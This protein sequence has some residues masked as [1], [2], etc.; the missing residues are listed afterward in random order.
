MLVKGNI[1]DILSMNSFT[2]SEE[3]LDVTSLQ[4]NTDYTRLCYVTDMKSGLTRMD[5]GFFTFYVKDKNANVITAR[6]FD[7]SDFINSGYTAN[8]FVNKPV[9]LTFSAQ[10]YN[11]SWSLIINSMELWTGDFDFA[12]FIGKVECS[13]STIKSVLDIIYVDNKD[14]VETTIKQYGVKRFNSVCG[15]RVGGFLLLANHVAEEILRYLDFDSISNDIMEVFV[16]SMSAYFEYLDI[17]EK[18]TVTKMNDVMKILS[19]VSIMNEKSNCVEEILDTCRALFRLGEPQHLYSHLI[20]NAVNNSLRTY[21]MIYRF[22]CMPGGSSNYTG[23][24]TLVKY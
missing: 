13:G 11:G 5:K 18:Y 1:G 7:I 23:G 9:K 20:V 10:K 16:I 17:C 21:D 6:L 22:N 2:S 8:A 14:L 4:E 24:V 12:S 3:Y 19:K 15:G